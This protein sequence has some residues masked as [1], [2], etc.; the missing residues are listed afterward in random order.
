MSIAFPDPSESPWT[1]PET[2]L[3]YEYV[4]GM[5]RPQDSSGGGG[6]NGGGG[7]GGGGGGGNIGSFSLD[8]MRVTQFA[9]SGLVESCGPAKIGNTIVAAG[10]PRSWMKWGIPFQKFA[11][12]KDDGKSWTYVDC[13]IDTYKI[14]CLSEGGNGKFYAIAY[15][16]D[17]SS[18][19]KS[20]I[21]RSFNGYD[22]TVVNELPRTDIRIATLTFVGRNLIVTANVSSATHAW[23]STDYGKT[24]QSLTSMQYSSGYHLTSRMG[25]PDGGAVLFTSHSSQRNFLFSP[26]SLTPTK[27]AGA[28]GFQTMTKSGHILRVADTPNTILID[29]GMAVFRTKAPITSADDFLN[30]EWEKLD[31]NIGTTKVIRFFESMDVNGTRAEVM[32]YTPKSSSGNHSQDWTTTVSFDEGETWSIV[33]SK[34]RPNAW[35]PSTL[36]RCSTNPV[37]E[38]PYWREQSFPAVTY[39]GCNGAYAD[40]GFTISFDDLKNLL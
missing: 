8:L 12:S 14:D 13:P 4:D 31:S 22:W 28:V 3:I 29:S 35:K 18:K 20:T 23:T 34:I 30:A 40:A 15:F 5:W 37:R 32:I 33:E 19:R 25:L 2:G 16:N 1:H 7:S 17:N 10:I 36:S 21:L 24:L 27:N 9:P 26:G 39:S 6:G 11:V 38:F